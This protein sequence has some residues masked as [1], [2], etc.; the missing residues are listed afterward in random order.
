[1]DPQVPPT[2][3][4]PE[5][6]SRYGGSIEHAITQIRR[7]MDDLMSC[8]TSMACYRDKSHPRTVLM[9]D[10]YTAKKEIL[11]SELFVYISFLSYIRMIEPKMDK[12][13]LDI[14]KKYSDLVDSIFSKES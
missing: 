13:L 12:Y 2:A 7:V 8:A 9:I 6:T 10:K 14:Q 5:P 3:D 1:M 11:Y 4:T